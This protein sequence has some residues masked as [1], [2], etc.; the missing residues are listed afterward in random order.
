MIKTLLLTG[1]LIGLAGI[2][3][4]Q[5]VD[6]TTVA[7]INRMPDAGVLFDRG[8]R[9]HTGDNPAWANPDFDDLGWRPIDVNPNQPP[10]QIRQIPRSGIGWLRL[11]FRLADSLRAQPLT[12][13]VDQR[14]ASEIYIN[15]KL[16]QRYGTVSSQP[17][18]VV[19]YGDN[20]EPV[21]VHFDRPGEQVLAVRFAVWPP[22]TAFSDNFYQFLLRIRL[23]GVAQAIRE[24]RKQQAT[25]MPS[26]VVSVVFLLLSLLHLAFFRYNPGQRANAYF[27]LYTLTGTV[28]F[29][30]LFAANYTHDIRLG[31]VLIITF[32]TLNQ[33]GWMG[34]VRALYSLFNVRVGVLYYALWGCLL[35]GIPLFFF[36]N[37]G[38]FPYLIPVVLILAEQVRLT[39]WALVNKRRGAA[40]V[41]AGFGI[42]L[43]ISVGAA[44]YHLSVAPLST[45]QLAFVFAVSFLSPVFSMSLFLGREFAL[46]SHLLQLKLI[47]VQ[48]LS[49]RTLA[50]E[51]EKQ[52]L[53]A[54]QNETLEQQVGERTAALNQSLT[55]LKATQAQLIQREK[56]ASLG[57]L[58]A[59]IAHEIQ[60]PLNFVTNFAEV[61]AEL[62]DELD[63]SVQTGDA[64]TTAALTAD[65]RA[66][67]KHIVQ[68]GQRASAIVRSMLEHS[69][70]GSGQRQPTNL[71]ALAGEYLK[72]A[73][74]GLRAKDKDLNARLV[75]DFD[76]TLGQVEV[77]PQ[78]LGRVLLNLYNNAFYAVRERQLAQ[79]NGYEP[80]V[81]VSTRRAENTVE[82]RIRDNGTGISESAKA[83]IFQP[84]F[85]TKPA[86]QGTGLGLSL[87]YDIITNGH[88][89][90]MH[91]DTQE[92]QDTEFLICL[93]L[94]PPA[95]P[96]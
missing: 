12:L 1:W 93:P 77:V 33:T 68:N 25:Q 75:T 20:P 2:G 46:D 80:L 4:A 45:G 5:K 73:Y 42:T 44:L 50:Q 19:P 21:V 87:A 62:A 76:A 9:M 83:K 79:Q 94:M 38:A 27:A 82:I 26:L 57:E 72:L 91:V 78:E 10:N 63:E 70:T 84:F 3:F 34:A 24:T 40:I 65:L 74:Q 55:H 95:A 86:G 51:Q 49:A 85:T 53:M 17:D 48:Q 23:N 66:N 67:M 13:S 39:L 18:R 28:G 8:W 58:T 35:I 90:E 59:G 47:E 41:A 81:S 61:S 36:G 16:F 14:V 31:L 30:C 69:R 96:A 71:N 56:M 7:L 52:H 22:I 32:Y 88:G 15:G 89:G 54:V 37:L 43:F 29:G 11:R 6:T 60:N 64:D 92:G